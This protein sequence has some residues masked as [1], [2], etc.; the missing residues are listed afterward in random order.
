MVALELLL[1]RRVRMVC[2]CKLICTMAKVLEYMGILL[3]G[4]RHY[5]GRQG[6]GC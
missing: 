1:K 5:L 6:L 3:D 2:L 4:N